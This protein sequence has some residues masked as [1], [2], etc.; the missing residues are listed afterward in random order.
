MVLVTNATVWLDEDLARMGLTD[1]ADE[2]VNSS[3][4]GSAKPERRIY[5]IAAERAGAA[6][7]R[8]LFVDDRQENVDAAVALGM[9]GVL[10]R[11][12]EDLRRALAPVLN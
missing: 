12:P 11:G 6:P 9:A 7:D 4:V 1:L 3:R 5:E 2:V 10:Y 8:C